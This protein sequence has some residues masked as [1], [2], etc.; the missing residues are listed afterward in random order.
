MR[1][2]AFQETGVGLSSRA[3]AGIRDLIEA[4]WPERW[5]SGLKRTPGEREWANTPPWVRIP[6]SP[7]A[8]EEWEVLATDAGARTFLSAA[9]SHG[10][11]ALRVVTSTLLL[12][13][14]GLN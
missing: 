2:T 8:S 6:V 9:T 7:P 1:L 3:Q 4:H 11:R 10:P 12:A 13:G 14:G 5:L